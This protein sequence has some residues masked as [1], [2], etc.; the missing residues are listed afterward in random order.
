[1]SRADPVV[2]P[3]ANFSHASGMKP[4]SR[5]IC[6]R[7]DFSRAFGMGAEFIIARSLPI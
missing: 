6:S 7:A 2:S 3:P 4:G 1:M 5:P